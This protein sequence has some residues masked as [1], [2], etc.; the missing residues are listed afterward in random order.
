MLQ[1]IRRYILLGLGE[2]GLTIPHWEGQCKNGRNCFD[3][4][5]GRPL[6][7]Y[8]LIGQPSWDFNQKEREIN[9]M[10]LF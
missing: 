3:I 10:A 6:D 5:Y 4:L 1:D 8:E 7:F 2:S 9:A